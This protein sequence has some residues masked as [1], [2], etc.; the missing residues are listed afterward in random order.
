MTVLSRG[1]VARLAQGPSGVNVGQIMKRE[2]LLGVFV[3]LNGNAEM[4][5]G[6][7]YCEQ[8]SRGDERGTGCR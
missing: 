1:Q 5:H 6:Q 4:V 3:F 8:Q 2:G 7:G